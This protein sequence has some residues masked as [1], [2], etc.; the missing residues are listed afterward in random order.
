M[1]V[2][3]ENFVFVKKLHKNEKTQ[4]RGIQ[5]RGLTVVNKSNCYR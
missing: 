4:I 3:G 1:A 2:I 5:N